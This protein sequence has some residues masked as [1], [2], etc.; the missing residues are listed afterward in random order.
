MVLPLLSYV[1]K[2][3]TAG[4]STKNR[5]GH[6]LSLCANQVVNSTVENVF[7]SLISHRKSL[8][9]SLSLSQP[10]KTLISQNPSFS[11]CFNGDFRQA[12]HR[13]TSLNCRPSSGFEAVTHGVS[14]GY[15]VTP[16]VSRHCSDT[17]WRYEVRIFASLANHLEIF[18]VFDLCELE[19][20]R[21]G[22]ADVPPEFG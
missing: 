11:P 14:A 21:L 13:Q 8:S 17:F 2:Q 7:T 12:H 6:C 18:L 4:A 16:R 22:L 3:L 20:C 9:Q 19:L 1:T 15:S 5:Y 10:K